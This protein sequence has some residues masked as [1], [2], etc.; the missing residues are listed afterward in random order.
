VST[1]NPRN[2]EFFTVIK[3]NLPILQNDEI[4]KGIIE[5]SHIIKC[6][7]QPANLKKTFDQSTI[8]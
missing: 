6:K 5:R 7:R 1:H 3:E 4:M 8:S 2:T